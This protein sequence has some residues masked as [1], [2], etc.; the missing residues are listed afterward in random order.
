MSEPTRYY[1]ISY[2]EY[3]EYTVEF[4]PSS[5]PVETV[6]AMVARLG[7]FGQVVKIDAVLNGPVIRGAD[8]FGGFSDFVNGMYLKDGDGYTDAVYPKLLD[9]VQK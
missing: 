4:V 8:S 3:S 7:W 2:G 1:I 5:L 9:E 6:V